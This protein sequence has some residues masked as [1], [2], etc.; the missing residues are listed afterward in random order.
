MQCKVEHGSVTNV[1]F[2]VTITGIQMAALTFTLF[3]MR[4]LRFIFPFGVSL[5]FMHV[6]ILVLKF[7]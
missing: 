2:K 7:I 1:Y 5:M 4:K 3:F 6:Y